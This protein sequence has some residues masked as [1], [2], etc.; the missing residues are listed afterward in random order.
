MGV[1][2][3][4]RPFVAPP[5]LPREVRDTLRAAFDDT[6]RDPAFLDEAKKMNLE[7]NPA[8]G[9]EVDRLVRELYR[10]PKDIVVQAK[11]AIASH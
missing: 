8:T 11:Q 4:A 5:E 6:M 9:D 1:Q 10:T 2:G 7:I 3:M